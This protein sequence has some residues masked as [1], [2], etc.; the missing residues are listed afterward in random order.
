MLCSKKKKKASV[1]QKIDFMIR[2][3]SPII[4]LLQTTAPYISLLPGGEQEP[5][6]D[7]NLKLAEDENQI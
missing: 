1:G 3:M 4:I 5:E 7:K 2:M 6:R